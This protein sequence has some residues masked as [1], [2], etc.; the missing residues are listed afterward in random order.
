MEYG[1]RE[2]FHKALLGAAAAHR[3]PAGAA[4]T[5]KL[6]IPGPFPGRVIETYHS[7]CLVNNAYQAAPI[8]NMME[9]GMKELTGAPDWTEAWR[10]F[11]EPSDVVGIKMTPVGGKLVCS[12]PEVLHTIFVGLKQAGV[13]AKNIVVYDRYRQQFMSVGYHRWLLEGVRWMWASEQYDLVQKNI[14]GY[15]EKHFME[16]AIVTPGE[17]PRD[18]RNR[19]SYIAKF[20]TQAVNKI[21]SFPCLKHHQS[22]GV[23]ISLKNMSHGFSNNVYRSHL[24]P[25]ANVCN[26]FIPAVVDLPI[27]RQKVVLHIVDG[28]KA[29]YDGGPGARREYVWEPKK[30]YFSTDPVAIDKIGLKAIDAKR[31]EA[32]LKP[33]ISTAEP[34]KAGNFYHQ[35]VDH[36]EL[37]GAIGLGVFEDAKMDYRKFDLS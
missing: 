20:V 22:A 27:I 21:I 33:L 37:A 9:K 13:Q 32:G 23:T 31:V 25:T 30:L 24:S 2:L 16:M 1:R 3:I 7:G 6:G 11:F 14:E 12:A 29:N 17:D 8:R 10:F 18:E 5:K 36:I 4:A 26:Y 15:D 28:V 19:R 35:Q 34:G